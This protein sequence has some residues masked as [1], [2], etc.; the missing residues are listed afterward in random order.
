MNRFRLLFV[1]V[2]L[3][4]ATIGVAAQDDGLVSEARH[5]RNPAAVLEWLDRSRWRIRDPHD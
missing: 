2:L 5:W 3:L 4:A 1:I